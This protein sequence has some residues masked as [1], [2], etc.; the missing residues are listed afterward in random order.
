MYKISVITVCYNAVDSIEATML[1]VLNQTYPNIEYIVIDGGSNDGT[2]DIIKKYADRLAYWVSEPDKGIYDAM[3]KGLDIAS[4]DYINFMNAGDIYF[5]VET[6]RDIF[7]SDHNEDILYGDSV[8][9][10]K[11]GSLNYECATPDYTLL[12]YSPI[13]RH[14]AS[15]IKT[16]I[17]KQY[18]FEIDLANKYGYSLDFLNL[19]KMYQSDCSF[20]KI[21]VI[22]LV[23]EKE[24]TSSNILKSIKYNYLISRIGCRFSFFLYI[25]Y[26]LRLAKYQLLS[27]HTLG[28]ISLGA[29]YFNCY[30]LNSFVAS[31]PMHWFRKKFCQLLK[32]RVGNGTTINMHQYFITPELISIGDN[33]HINRGC[34]IDGRG[35]C[36]I[37]NNVSISYNVSILTGSHDVQSRNFSGKYLPVVIEDYSW[38]GANAI[39][40]QNVRIGKGAVVCSGSVV[41]HD[42]A[43]YSIIGGVPAKKI[44]IRNKDLE[45]TCRW[46]IPFV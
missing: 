11:Y 19:H 14:G 25:K 4:G 43:P 35:L 8:V 46:T 37:G 7:G 15:F 45:Y 23:Y 40:L 21:D 34:L 32:M 6:L 12:S 16:S 39:I 38:I 42:V 13:F 41:T 18:K 22:V 9:K 17:H 20:K 29:Y 27:I 5:K 3:N 10:D 28:K 33:T 24:G 36:R 26:L 31:F 2:V 30:L 44:G 1:S